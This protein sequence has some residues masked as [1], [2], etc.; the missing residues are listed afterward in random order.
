VEAGS[1]WDELDA[2]GMQA[3]VTR[4][5]SKRC[6]CVSGCGSLPARHPFLH[7][8]PA[9]ATSVARHAAIVREMTDAPS[10]LSSPDYILKK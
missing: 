5:S 10:M 6:Y 9:H 7:D 2:G 3:V 8:H 4:F 1:V